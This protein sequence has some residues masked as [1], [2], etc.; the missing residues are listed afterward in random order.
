M[1]NYQEI[2]S[3]PLMLMAWFFIHFW[4]KAC[5]LEIYPSFWFKDMRWILQ[6]AE[7]TNKGIRSSIVF[8]FRVILNKFPLLLMLQ[9][10]NENREKDR[11]RGS[12]ACSCC[13]L[14]GSG[15]SGGGNLVWIGPQAGFIF[16]EKC[17]ITCFGEIPV[18]QFYNGI[19]LNRK[20]AFGIHL[21]L[22]MGRDCS[23][24]VQEKK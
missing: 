16:S 4:A 14:Y 20:Y 24:S 15:V 5:S 13:H 18:Y 3:H 11:M 12:D 7:N 9:I 8:L 22:L 21:S 17:T 2:F 1:K 23:S 19:H 6:I 10:S